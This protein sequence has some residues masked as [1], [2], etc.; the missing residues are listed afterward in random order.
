M[1]HPPIPFSIFKM[2]NHTPGYLVWAY[3]PDDSGTGWGVP[4]ICQPA[5]GEVDGDVFGTAADA[6]RTAKILREFYPG[7]LFAVLHTER[8]PKLAIA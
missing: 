8:T 4:Y 7:H 3:I 6:H 1:R 5:L 2:Q